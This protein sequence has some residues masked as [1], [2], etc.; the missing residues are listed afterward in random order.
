LA[1]FVDELE[2]GE[3]W[4]L[5]GQSG[6]SDG[7]EED[8]IGYSGYYFDGAK[9]GG[10]DAYGETGGALRLT[11]EYRGWN[12]LEAF[13][14]RS[15]RRWTELGLGLSEEKVERQ[16]LEAARRADEARNKR[17]SGLQ[18]LGF[19]G[20]RLEDGETAARVAIPGEFWS[21]LT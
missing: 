6:G 4:E 5:E 12:V 16:E 9:G 13:W 21:I 8:R 15:V 20:M 1:S 10:G 7:E 17:S 2:R 14:D 11:G 18:G 3:G 19:G